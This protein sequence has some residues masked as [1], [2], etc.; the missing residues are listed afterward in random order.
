MGVVIRDWCVLEAE[1]NVRRAQGA[2]IVST[3]GIFDLVHV[4]HVRYLHTARKLGDLLVVGVNSD[5]GTRRLKGPLRPIVPEDERAELLAALACVDYVTVFEEPTPEALLEVVRPA[6]HVK[7]GDY[8]VEQMP[9]TAVV[10]RHGGDVVKAEFVP[11]H[12]TTDIIER[13]LKITAGSR[14]SEEL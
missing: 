8:D 5:A 14:A 9:E 13:V 7:G 4:G 3:N 11:D 12:S 6:K 1:L 2:C 10:R